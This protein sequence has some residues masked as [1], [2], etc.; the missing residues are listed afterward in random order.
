MI[1]GYISRWEELT[2]EIKDALE[3]D[4]TTKYKAFAA[5]VDQAWDAFAKEFQWLYSSTV[6]AIN[7]RISQSETLS[8][9]IV[10]P[11]F[12]CQ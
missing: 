2:S 7:S 5:E 6:S 10:Q 12:Y 4:L 9:V 1:R 8:T 3:I 11:E